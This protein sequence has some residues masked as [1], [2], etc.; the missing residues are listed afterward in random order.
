MPLA[1]LS[2][3]PVCNANLDKNYRTKRNQNFDIN[4]FV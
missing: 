3:T 4:I 1:K 2:G